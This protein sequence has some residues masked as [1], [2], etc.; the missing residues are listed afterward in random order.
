MH[1]AHKNGGL[2]AAIF[3]ADALICKASNVRMLEYS[4]AR[5]PHQPTIRYAL[6]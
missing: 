4:N 3:V 2:Q 1:N 6:L 5:F